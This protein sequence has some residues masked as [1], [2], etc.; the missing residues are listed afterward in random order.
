MAIFNSYV[1]L[2]EIKCGNPNAINIIPQRLSLNWGF[3]VRWTPLGEGI[4]NINQMSLCLTSLNP[5]IIGLF[6]PVVHMY[7]Y[8]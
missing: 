3:I 6:C 2:P 4:L 5:G 1:S 8:I 7:I